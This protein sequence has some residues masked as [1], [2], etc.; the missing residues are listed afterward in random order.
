MEHTVNMEM[1]ELQAVQ[2]IAALVGHVQHG[3]KGQ[4]GA[5]REAMAAL[6]LAHQAF[7][8]AEAPLP[9]DD[10]LSLGMD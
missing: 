5:R 6:R 8:G 2:V 3:C 10:L 4:R 9:D 7:T 1:S